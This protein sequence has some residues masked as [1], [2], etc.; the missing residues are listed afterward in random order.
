ML[1][2]HDFI[3]VYFLGSIDLD[4]KALG[5]PFSNPNKIKNLSDYSKRKAQSLFEIRRVYGWLPIYGYPKEKGKSKKNKNDKKITVVSFFYKG[6][7]QRRPLEIGQ[8]LKF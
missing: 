4:L 8:L 6:V 7:E 3:T 2:P 1:R 5:K